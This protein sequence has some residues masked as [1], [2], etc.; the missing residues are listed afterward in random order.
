MFSYSFN[1]IFHD[2]F[3]GIGQDISLGGLHTLCI[4]VDYLFVFHL[5]YI[6]HIVFVTYLCFLLEGSIQDND[7]QHIY[8]DQLLQCQ[9]RCELPVK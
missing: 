7:N 8:C 2:I 3:R 6:L 9:H 5:L 4:D 1:F